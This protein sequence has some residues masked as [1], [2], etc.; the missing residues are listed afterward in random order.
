MRY[1]PYHSMILYI[2]A[3][4]KNCLN[5]AILTD[6][7]KYSLIEYK[8]RKTVTKLNQIFFTI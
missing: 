5:E 8:G 3:S 7:T 1:S 2:V 6:D 4:D